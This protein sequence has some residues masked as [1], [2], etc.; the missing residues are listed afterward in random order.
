MAWNDPS[1][2]AA[3]E[4][5]AAPI[6][7]DGLRFRTPCVDDAAC[8]AGLACVARG[9]Y[10]TVAAAELGCEKAHGEKLGG[11]SC[12]GDV[13]CAS[14]LCAPVGSAGA[15]LCYEACNANADCASGLSCGLSGGTLD[16]DPILA[17]LG[18]LELPGCA[19]P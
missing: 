9:S 4:D 8:G 16:L 19:A 3:T 2:P 1:D 18:E 13:E 14:G 15:L 12:V 10:L 7:G 5:I 6:T 11:E 17:G